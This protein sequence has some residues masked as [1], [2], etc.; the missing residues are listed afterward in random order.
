MKFKL[1]IFILN[2]LC[3]KKS[4]D[5]NSAIQFVKKEHTQLKKYYKIRGHNIVT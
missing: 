1:N 4:K 2:D 3:K 5:R